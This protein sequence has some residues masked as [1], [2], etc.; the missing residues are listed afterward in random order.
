MKKFLTALLAL[1]LA[2][3]MAFAMVAC[4]ET[5]KDPNN[6]NGNDTEQGG[7]NTGDNTGDNTGGNEEDESLQ[8]VDAKLFAQTIL[9]QISTAEGFSVTLN[10][11]ASGTTTEPDAEGNS[12]STT[13]DESVSDTYTLESLYATN[14]L[15]VFEDIYSLF[16]G[17]GGIEDFFAGTVEP[18]VD[19][20]G[21][22]YT[23][24][25]TTEDIQPAVEAVQGFFAKG[26][27]ENGG[28]TPSAA[29]G[30]TL[31]DIFVMIMP[32]T[33]PEGANLSGDATA[34]EIAKAWVSEIFSAD[35][36]IGNLFDLLNTVLEEKEVS[37]IANK[38]VR[39]VTGAVLGAPLDLDTLGAL[40]DSLKVTV[41]EDGSISFEN[42][43]V[44]LGDVTLAALVGPL[45]DSAGMTGFYPLLGAFITQSFWDLSISEIYTLVQYVMVSNG[46]VLP[47]I[48]DI[49]S[50]TVETA[51]LTVIIETDKD[52]K[53]TSFSA[54]AAFK[55][56]IT[57]SGQLYAADIEASAKGTFG[58]EAIA[59]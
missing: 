50:A 56:S 47:T 18:L 38:I 17:I 19:N 13:I 12:V 23:I 58:Y 32:Q 11:S 53:L 33:A 26:T 44:A 7:N 3:A 31:G 14:I 57:M 49:V 25:V 52:M 2:L 6:G 9:E 27:D 1:I 24:T 48:E 15:T 29:E 28:E 54:D 55:G 8:P 4:E 39:I 37:D 40:L 5:N 51:T 41:K 36:T 16:A 10:A 20:S 59:A 34:D 46:T 43:T 45:L 42:G 35:F 30:V 21:Y 22:E